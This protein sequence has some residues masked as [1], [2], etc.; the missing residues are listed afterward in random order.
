MYIFQVMTRR[1]SGKFSFVKL[2]VV[3]LAMAVLLLIAGLTVLLPGGEAFGFL[4][5][6]TGVKAVFAASGGVDVSWRS[7]SGATGYRIGWT[8]K[9]GAGQ[10]AHSDARRHQQRKWR[11]G[12]HR[13]RQC[14]AMLDEGLSFL[15]GQH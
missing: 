13:Y 10:I 11:G 5:P 9:D 14:V 3:R 7:V 12:F 15:G 6:P 1:V 8:E 4:V 2:V